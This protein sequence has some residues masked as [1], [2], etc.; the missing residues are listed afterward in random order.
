MYPNTR[1]MYPNT[2][3]MYP[4]TRVK[5]MGLLIEVHTI[6]WTSITIPCTLHLG[7]RYTMLIIQ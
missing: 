4:N 3:V 2:R 6:A 5:G 1:V 7:Q